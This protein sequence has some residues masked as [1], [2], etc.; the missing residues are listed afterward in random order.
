MSVQRMIAEPERAPPPVSPVPDRMEKADPIRS[1][2]PLREAIETF[3]R[4]PH[5]RFLAVVDSAGR[6][7]GA[8]HEIVVRDLLF[9]PFGHALLANPGCRWSLADLVRP[10]ASVDVEAP[11][12]WLIAAFGEAGGGEG[13]ILTRAGRYLGLLPSQALLRIAAE[14]ERGLH[15]EERAKA[16]RALE[17]SETLGRAF[18]RFQE[19]VRDFGAQLVAAAEEIQ[20]TAAGVSERATLNGR[21]ALMVTAASSQSAQ[22]IS[23]LAR[24]GVAL[25]HQVRDIEARVAE[26]KDALGDAVEQVEISASRTASLTEAADEIG[27]VISLISGITGKVNMLAI[28]AAIE[29][30]RG[31]EAGKGFAVVAAEVKALAVQAK[32]AAAQIERRIGAVR[33]ATADTAEANRTINTIVVAVD[34]AASSILGS[35]AQQ[36]AAATTIAATIEQAAAASAEVSSHVAEMGGRAA[37]ATRIASELGV[38]AEALTGK[39]DRLRARVGDFIGEIQAAA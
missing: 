5:V 22:G 36:A 38:V 35:V 1:D 32:A 31:G 10:C 9:S 24:T 33:A 29:A 3:R 27:G 21:Q 2:A 6:P 18:A 34:G 17:R 30:A 14:R 7:L 25:A 4:F 37:T 28:N 23:D 16:R 12:E 8:V 11:V 26:V 15:H 13:I 20:A 39:A 19:D